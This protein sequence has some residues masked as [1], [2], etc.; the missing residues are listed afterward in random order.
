[1][2]TFCNF[3]GF[4]NFCVLLSNFPFSLI[5]ILKK[6]GF[7]NNMFSILNLII[8]TQRGLMLLRICLKPWRFIPTLIF[9]LW[10][11]FVYFLLVIKYALH[12]YM[13]TCHFRLAIRKTLR[14]LANELW[15]WV[16]IRFIIPSV[17]VFITTKFSIVFLGVTW[18]PCL[19]MQ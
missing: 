11:S 10:F 19:F 9:F 2:W 13:A 3:W 16:F 7:L 4:T 1:M 12:I 14:N 5:K 8:V 18:L 15:R 6:C 17:E